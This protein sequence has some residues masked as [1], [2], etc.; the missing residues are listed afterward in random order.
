MIRIADSAS[1][2]VARF[3]ARP[4]FPE[5]A[6]TA[7]AAKTQMIVSAV[8]DQE[9][10]EATPEEISE[11]LE[12]MAQQYGMEKDKLLSMIGPQ[13]VS[14]IGGDIKVRKAID[15]MYENAVKK[16]AEEKKEDAE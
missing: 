9:G 3:C 13:N 8:A 11:E 7:A 6:E 15:F 14:M 4:A 2:A 12:K 10:F 1:P 16:P 5:E